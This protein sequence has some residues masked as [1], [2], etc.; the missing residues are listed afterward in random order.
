MPHR[1]TCHACSISGAAHATTYGARRDQSRHR[2]TIHGGI[3]P[4]A[5]DHVGYAAPSSRGPLIVLV[6]FAVLIAIK[7]LT[8][9]APD[10]MARWI[11]LI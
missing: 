4:A 7:E 5:G 8:G 1:Y 11:G 3:E 2:D 9:V 6:V 10:D